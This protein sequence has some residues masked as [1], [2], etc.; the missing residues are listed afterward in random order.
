MWRR[1]KSAEEIQ[2][3][4]VIR[5]TKVPVDRVDLFVPYTSIA[6]SSYAKLCLL[7]QE[8]KTGEKLA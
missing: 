7:I 5:P 2:C 6:Q 4:N 3:P 1:E 8:S